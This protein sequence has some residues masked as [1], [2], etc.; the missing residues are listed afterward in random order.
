MMLLAWT[1]Q[2]EDDFQWLA[3]GILT[4]VLVVVLGVLVFVLYD[5]S[6]EKRHVER[7]ERHLNKI[8]DPSE[9]L[10]NSHPGIGTGPLSLRGLKQGK[11]DI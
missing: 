6:C 8:T 1:L 2:D 10:N 9:A 4:T 5:R 7:M 3:L 11:P